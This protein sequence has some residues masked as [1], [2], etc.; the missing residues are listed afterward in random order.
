M[1]RVAATLG[2][3]G[4]LLS[5][6]YLAACWYVVHVMITMDRKPTRV[7]PTALGVPD[8]EEVSFHTPDG[9]GLVGWFVPAEGDRVIVLVHGIYSNAWDGQASDVVRAYHEADFN[10]FL[11]DSRGQGRSE[12]TLGLG[13]LERQDV[14]AAVAHVLARGFRAGRIGVHGTSYGAATALLAAA[15]LPE[16]GAV[17]ADSAFADARDV[18]LGEVARRTG[19]SI[20][21]T[22]P[23]T[24]G[25]AFIAKRRYGAELSAGSP[26]QAMAA[27]APRPVLLIHGERD[28]IIPVASIDRLHAAAPGSTTVWVLPGRQ[29]TEGVRLAPDYENESPLLGV[30]LAKVTGFFR[31]HL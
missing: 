3:L 8:V 9:I 10:V 7:S 21:W 17:V 18:I 19:L 22:R 15:E 4:V 28:P 24:P 26:E 14:Q 20:R 30:F 12:G 29:H 16:I 31:D 23:L 6:A 11:Y 25:L 27:I 5:G 13:W 1:R 2:I